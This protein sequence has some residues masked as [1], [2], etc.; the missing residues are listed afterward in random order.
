MFL[1]LFASQLG[2][3]DMSP[4]ILKLT[5]EVRTVKHHYSGRCLEVEEQ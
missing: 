3:D 1:L 4:L 5:G 2:E